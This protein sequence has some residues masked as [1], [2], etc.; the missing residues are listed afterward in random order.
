MRLRYI[1]LLLFCT[2]VINTLHAQPPTSPIP[3]TREV[4]ID[5]WTML[6]YDPLERG[7]LLVVNPVLRKPP[8]SINLN[9]YVEACDGRIFTAGN[10]NIVAPR[11]QVVLNTKLGKPNPFANMPP[12]ERL[13]LFLGTCSEEQWKLLGNSGLG[14]GNV[15]EE[16]K[17]LFLSLLPVEPKIFEADIVAGSKP[18]EF[19]FANDKHTPVA[20]TALKLSIALRN[21][22]SF[23]EQGKNETTV[24]S[25][26]FDLKA[27]GKARHLE[28]RFEMLDESG[29]FGQVLFIHQLNKLKPS[30]IEPV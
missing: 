20:P 18:Y 3:A 5:P 30:A 4:P 23:Y 13:K 22:Y 28:S 14:I 26:D 19:T 1:T 27:G 29:A 25:G 10:L 7:P 21:Q 9:S 15:T 16:Q 2:C 6:R 24:T 17:A 8:V 11:E 12:A